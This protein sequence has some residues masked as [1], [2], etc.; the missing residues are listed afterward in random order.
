MKVLIT[1]FS[2]TGNTEKI[3]KSMKDVLVDYDVDLIHAKDVDPTTLSSY[4]IVFLG[5][6]VYASRIDKSILTMI[7]KAVPDLPT[8]FAY[9][10]THASL[11]LF[12]E[13]FKRITGVIKKHNCEIIGEFDCVGENL[14]IPLDTQLAMI[15]NLPEDQR[16][17]A[18]KDREKIKGRPNEMDLENAKKFAISLA[19]NL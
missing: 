14:G 11:K 6:G 5:S 13:P 19:K 7:K 2:N 10:C 15:E 18:K 12:Q 16:E 4:D 1:Y 17:K 3:A 8:K 9:F